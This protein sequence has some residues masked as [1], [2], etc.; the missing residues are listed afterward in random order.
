M[1]RHLYLMLSFLLLFVFIPNPVHAINNQNLDW[2]IDV[3]DV[4][5]YTYSEELPT[6]VLDTTVIRNEYDFNVTVVG[7]PILHDDIDERD[8]FE[9]RLNTHYELESDVTL[10]TRIRPIWTAYPIGNWPI[11]TDIENSTQRLY[12]I[13][14]TFSES[15][16]E[17]SVTWFYDALY[18][19]EKFTLHISKTTG[20][21]NEA[22][23]WRKNKQTS[24]VLTAQIE[25]EVLPAPPDVWDYVGWGVTLGS[26]GIISVVSRMLYRA[27]KEGKWRGTA[28][29]TPVSK[30][31]DVFFD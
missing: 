19:R 15:F 6:G 28:E 22:K 24:A 7:L 12:Y 10:P 3:G 30:D 11:I 18:F 25:L 26:I 4:F 5:E 14:A 1:K 17:W 23:I 2:G 29:E 13:N 31:T 8:D 9:P 20:V 21:L 16:S 27:R